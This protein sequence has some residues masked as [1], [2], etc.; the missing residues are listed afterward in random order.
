MCGFPGGYS[1]K[2]INQ[3]LLLLFLPTRFSIGEDVAPSG[4]KK[5]FTIDPA[6]GALSISKDA[7]FEDPA[8]DSMPSPQV[9][10]RLRVECNASPLADSLSRLQESVTKNEMIVVVNILN[11]NEERPVFTDET[12][13]V[14]GY[15]DQDFAQ[16]LF[17]GSVF[18]IKVS[19]YT[20][21]S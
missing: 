11:R 8:F 13:G 5:W 14:V 1:S 19:H 18:Q 10:L 9:R 17:P 3:F 6:T 20:V 7:N 21:E 12:P 15:P 2:Y 16:Q 4:L